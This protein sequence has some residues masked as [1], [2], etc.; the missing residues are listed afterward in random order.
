MWAASGA[1]RMEAT[2]RFLGRLFG[3]PGRSR[4]A[5]RGSNH[6]NFIRN[7]SGA[8]ALLFGLTIIPILGFVGGAIDYANAYRTRTKLQ[9]AV[10]A[11]ALAAGRELDAGNTSDGARSVANRVLEANLGDNFPSYNAVFNITEVEGN[12]TVVASADTTVQTYILGVIGVRDM[13]V[14]VGSTVNLAG[15][16]LELAMVLDNSGSMSGSKLRD[17]K[18]ASKRLT[19]ILFDANRR[20]EA[21]KIGVVPFAAAVNVGSDNANAG[22]MDTQARS[23]IH[24]ENF[25]PKKGQAGFKNRF[26]IFNML[27]STSWA[28]CVEA[29]PGIHM[30]SDSEPSISDGDT[31]FVP[32][33]A[34]DEPDTGGWFSSYSNNYLNDGG[35]NCSGSMNGKSD[36]WRQERSCKYNNERP[37]GGSGPNYMCDPRELQPLTDNQGRV[38]S[39]IENMRAQGNTN[40]MEGVMWGWRVLSPGEPF[41]EGRPYDD[42]ENT[43]FM[44]VM[45]DGANTHNGTSNMNQ[46]IYSAF[47]YAKNGRLRSPTSNSSRLAEAMDEKTEEACTNVKAAGIIV[48][49]IAFDLDDNNT[50]AMLRRCA[51]GDSRA[52]SIDNGDAL[53]S[54]FEAI[55]GEIN[56]LRI[57][58]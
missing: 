21:V 36:T 33:L 4:A 10:D 2:L 45:T 51:S 22:W 52:F 49:T 20:P 16:N 38:I 50:V 53:I 29:R 43:K 56:K 27:R 35:G 58:S 23:S 34:P 39:S 3:A 42:R 9:S 24:D 15:G 13:P 17:L 46:S 25:S 26:D 41:T 55:A 47:G 11:A 19:Q 31:F 44:I 40:I 54:I 48:Y 28:G 37:S 1:G 57:A 32:M 30:T 18:A 7:T 14:T 8:V 12:R 5:R 6:S